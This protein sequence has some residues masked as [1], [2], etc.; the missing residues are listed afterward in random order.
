MSTNEDRLPAYRLLAAIFPSRTERVLGH[1]VT[2]AYDRGESGV[3]GLIGDRVD[4]IKCA[5]TRRRARW[6]LTHQIPFN[7]KTS[8]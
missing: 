5:I 2:W 7:K 6:H 1:I 4:D 3:Y 8:S